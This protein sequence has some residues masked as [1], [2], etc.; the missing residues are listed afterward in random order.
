MG[1]ESPHGFHLKDSPIN[2]PEPFSGRSV[3]SDLFNDDDDRK[4]SAASTKPPLSSSSTTAV[5]ESEKLSE[6]LCCGICLDLMV[7][8]QT[9]VPCGHSYCGKCL[10]SHV[11]EQQQQ[12]QPECPECRAAMRSVVPARQLNG[13]ME[14]LVTTMPAMFA[15]NDLEHYHL[16]LKTEQCGGFK[17]RSSSN[18]KVC[19][20]FT[21]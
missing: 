4:P 11:T 6:Q 7:H 15:K 3:S 17:V 5:V 16:R 2:T 1:N 12:Q 21:F 10:Q 14:T 18:L 8:P 20:V 9:V 13:L 19:L